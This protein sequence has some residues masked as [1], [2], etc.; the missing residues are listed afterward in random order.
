[1][2][3]SP[4]KQTKNDFKNQK[5]NEKIPNEKI[6]KGEKKDQMKKIEKVKKHIKNS[7]SNDDKIKKVIDKDN[8]KIEQN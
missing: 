2:K 1:M 6:Y 5:K 8:K 7:D 3:K 4:N